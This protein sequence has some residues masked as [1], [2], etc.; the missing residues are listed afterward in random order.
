LIE[1]FSYQQYSTYGQQVHISEKPLK[2][3]RIESLYMRSSN[4]AE[5]TF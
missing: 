3:G 5:P 2:A 1:S 4:S